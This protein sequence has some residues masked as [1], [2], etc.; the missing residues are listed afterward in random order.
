ML[1]GTL[2]SL[3]DVGN[4][5]VE[6]IEDCENNHLDLKKMMNESKAMFDA[7][8]DQISEGRMGFVCV[9]IGVYG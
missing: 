3:S 1:P 6:S 5:L 7:L 2:V 8:K 4:K 9:R